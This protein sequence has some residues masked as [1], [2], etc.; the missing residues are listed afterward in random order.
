MNRRSSRL[1]KGHNDNPCMSR[2]KQRN[3]MIEIP[4]RSQNS[5]TKALGGGKNSFIVVAKLT[6]VIKQYRLVATFHYQTNR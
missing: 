5:R 3:G 2:M 1:P 4:V 6:Y